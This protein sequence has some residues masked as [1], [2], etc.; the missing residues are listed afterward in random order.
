MSAAQAREQ[1]L[2]RSER[3]AAL[4]RVQCARASPEV[5]SPKGERMT[6]SPWTPSRDAELRQL[7]DAGVLTAEIRRRLGVTKSAAVGRAY[8]RHLT[9]RVGALQIEERGLVR[10]PA[11][12]PGSRRLENCDRFSHLR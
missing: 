12:S 9:P 3:K 6:P 2:H 8:R 10:L 4:P 7:W 11:L 5:S 1:P